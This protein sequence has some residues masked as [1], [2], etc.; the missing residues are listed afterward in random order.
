MSKPTMP[1]MRWGKRNASAKHRM[2]KRT[3]H[4]EATRK[5]RRPS[6]VT[7]IDPLVYERMLQENNK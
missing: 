4:T 1:T 3:I 7:F 6:A 5:G 2:T